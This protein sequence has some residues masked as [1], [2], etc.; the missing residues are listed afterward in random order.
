MEK[1]ISVIIPVY[2]VEKYLDRCVE[3]VVNQTD[4]NLNYFIMTQDLTKEQSE[5]EKIVKSELPGYVRTLI[6]KSILLYYE[7]EKISEKNPLFKSLEEIT[8]IDCSTIF[9]N[10]RNAFVTNVDK[11]YPEV[12][13]FVLFEAVCKSVYVIN[14]YK[15]EKLNKYI[16]T[17]NSQLKH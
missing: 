11:L 13:Y 12:N 10:V 3:S 5:V 1:K 4:Q 9:H 14:E 8:T 17:K 15:S 6:N 7:I 16:K 2:K